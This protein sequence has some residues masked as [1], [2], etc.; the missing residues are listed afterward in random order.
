[1]C[2]YW[3]FRTPAVSM[4]LFGTS[5]AKTAQFRDADLLSGPMGAFYNL[6]AFGMAFAM[7]P[8]ARKMGASKLH[9]LALVGAAVGM[10]VL[11]LANSQLLMWGTMILMGIG[12]GSIMGNPY[13]VLANSIPPE[14]TGVYM[15]IFNMMIC[16]PMIIF[17]VTMPFLYTGKIVTLFGF[18]TGIHGLNLLHDDPRNVL[19]FG[20]VCM[21]LA[22]VAIYR[23][24]APQPQAAPV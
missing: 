24:K 15:G 9:A 8:I 1:M 4:A 23:V 2:C 12:W 3:G 20:G 22:A 16:A 17:A 21:F 14:R 13:V 18:N 19:I 11:P 7:V 6:V 10:I 5:D